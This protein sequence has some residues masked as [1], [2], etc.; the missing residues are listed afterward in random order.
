MRAQIVA[1]LSAVF[2]VTAVND[3]FESYEGSI[4]KFHAADYESCLNRLGKFVENALRCLEYVRTGNMPTEI[5]SSARTISDL[6][7]S[8]NLNESVSTLIPGILGSMIYD[9]RSKKGAVH[10]KGVDPVQ[11][12]ATLAITAASW[13]MSELLR[14]YH[15]ADDRAVRMYLAALMRTKIPYIETISNEIAVT[16][17]VPTVIEVALLLSTEPSDGMSR[18]QVGRAAR[19]S[20]ASVTKGLAKLQSEKWAHQTAAG[21][22]FLTGTGE[23]HLAEWIASQ[24]L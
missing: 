8:K 9:V 24:P 22:Y 13:V 7:A 19:C 20:P 2:P 21:S 5:K 10:V 16:K 6:K 15:T 17:K 1:N 11:I 12:D 4:R 3:L 23:R 14:L 18:T